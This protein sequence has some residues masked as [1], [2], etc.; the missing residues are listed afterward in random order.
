MNR[1]HPFFRLSANLLFATLITFL[2]AATAK[3]GN[4]I[5]TGRA[6]IPE[7]YDIDDFTGE[8]TLRTDCEAPTYIGEY[9]GID[10]L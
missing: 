9:E 7:T 6:D 4:R 1:K 5:R 8:V 2:F 10:G 3:T